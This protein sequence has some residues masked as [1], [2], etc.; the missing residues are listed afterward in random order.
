MPITRAAALRATKNRIEVAASPNVN[1]ASSGNS[2]SDLSPDPLGQPVRYAVDSKKESQKKTEKGNGKGTGKGNGKQEQ[3]ARSRS[4]PKGN[5]KDL[6]KSNTNIPKK[7]WMDAPLPPAPPLKPGASP[8]RREVKHFQ[9]GFP[10]YVV[11][12]H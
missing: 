7:P 2:S 6:P 4:W 5:R 3:K 8:K 9:D 12:G 1:K 11:R 10:S